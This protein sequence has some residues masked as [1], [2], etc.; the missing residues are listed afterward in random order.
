MI[1]AG[2]AKEETFNYGIIRG[3][4]VPGGELIF[5][6]EGNDVFVSVKDSEGKVSK[7]KIDWQNRILLDRIKS[8]IGEVSENITFAKNNS[9]RN[10]FK[11]VDGEKK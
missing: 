4:K 11:P 1:V 7:I 5:E 10:S 2:T 6:T 8:A 9:E 3:F